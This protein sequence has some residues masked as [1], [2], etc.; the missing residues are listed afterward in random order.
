MDLDERKRLRVNYKRIDYDLLW[1]RR[2]GRLAI[3]VTRGVEVVVN[4]S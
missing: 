4:T 3:A 1:L 2:S